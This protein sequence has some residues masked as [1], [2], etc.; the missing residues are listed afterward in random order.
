MSLGMYLSVTCAEDVSLIQRRDIVRET[1]GS[2]LGTTVIESLVRVCEEWPRGRLPA[3]YN[4]PVRS[5]APV[6]ILSGELDPQTPPLWGAEVARHLPN[7]LHIVMRGVAHGPFPDCGVE[8]MSQFI[9][10]GSTK[11]LDTSC[12]KELVRPPFTVSASE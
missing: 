6:L 10:K 4:S 3:A 5:D 9:S 11:G 8:M 2:F 12:V 7:G 1:R